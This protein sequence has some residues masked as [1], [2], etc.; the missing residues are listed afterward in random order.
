MTEQTEIIKEK[1]DPLFRFSISFFIFILFISLWLFVYKYSIDSEINTKN[2][3]LAILDKSIKD[4]SSD[5]KIQIYSLYTANKD[6]LLSLSKK[7]NINTYINYLKN[8]AKLYQVSFNWFSYD[9]TKITTNLVANTDTNLA[10]LKLVKFIGDY[11]NTTNDLVSLWFIP[12]F[13]WN[14]KINTNIVF[15]LK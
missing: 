2:S 5:K 6:T 15:D 4:I 3:D 9:G 14:D 13:S 7:S 10:Y 12:S 11:R 1:K 8:T